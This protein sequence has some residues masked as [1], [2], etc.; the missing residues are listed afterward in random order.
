[1]DEKKFG[2]VDRTEEFEKEDIE[3]NK[4]MS[5][6]AY[7]WWLV[8]VT[9]VAAPNSKFAR[10]HANQG[11]ILAIA[12]TVFSILAGILTG[13]LGWIPVI[14]WIVSAVFWLIDAAIFALMLY[15]IITTAQGKAKELPFIGKFRI[16][17]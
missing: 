2:V 13:V 15:L 5:V 10:F 6:L 17:K 14:G 4:V 1:M 9:I 3:K 7:I 12:L 16:L 11:L 8:I